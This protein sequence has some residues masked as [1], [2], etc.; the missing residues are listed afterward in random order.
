MEA[1][2]MTFGQLHFRGLNLGDARRSRR[3][4]ELVDAMHKHP[5]GT[6]RSSHSDPQTTRLYDR[7]QK[8]VTRNIVERISI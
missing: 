8:T 5:G 1:L 7:R 2:A 6:Q 3:L 4:P